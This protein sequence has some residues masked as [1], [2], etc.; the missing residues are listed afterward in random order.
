MAELSRVEVLTPEQ[1]IAWWRR[2]WKPGEHVSIA[3]L[4]GSGKSTLG[5]YL[6]SVRKWVLGLDAK[7]LDSTLSATGWPRVDRWP[8][9]WHMR[10]AVKDNDPCRVIIG[11]KC[12]TDAEFERNANLMR[13]VL[14][15][16]WAQGAWTVWADEGQ[17]LADHRYG[18]AGDQL[19]K[20]LISARDR[21]ISLVY[22][23]QRPQIGRSTPS[24]NAAYTQSAWL[25]VARTRDT[26]VADRFAEMAGRPAP[27]MRGLV[28]GLPQHWWA[29]LGLDPHEP[30]RL[31]KPP[32][33]GRKKPG[34][35]AAQQSTLSHFLW[36][37]S[38]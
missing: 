29:C 27:E 5:A 12:S 15:G 38:A 35:R 24:A 6:V 3:A 26:R 33:L 30:I 9:P 4:T 17:L 25:F 36:G 8:L 1:F 21:G 28:A 37:Q 7:G 22:T 19:E 23:V 10:N 2:A 18:N 11:R 31:V 20:M 34:E 14:A 13:R 32:K 16:A